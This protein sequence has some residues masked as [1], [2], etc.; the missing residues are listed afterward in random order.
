LCSFSSWWGGLSVNALSNVKGQLDTATG[1]TTKKIEAAFE[2]QETVVRYRS[3]QR[4]GLL[5]AFAHDADTVA[6]AKER[7][8]VP[9]A[10]SASASRDWARCWL[11]RRAARWWRR[12]SSVKANG[13]RPTIR[14]SA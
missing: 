11:R 13:R 7:I 10:S 3:E 14:C 6:Q 2:L 4:R 12:S 9:A 1:Q 8:K 5:G